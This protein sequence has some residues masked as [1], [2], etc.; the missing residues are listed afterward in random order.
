MSEVTTL[1]PKSSARAGQVR[2]PVTGRMTRLAGIAIVG[3]VVLT[4]CHTDNTPTT[5]GDEVKAAF[6]STCE[7][8]VQV[9][10]GT[11]TS[12]APPAYCVC[13]YGV[14]EQNVP[15]NDDDKKN[16]DNGAKFANYSGKVF[17]DIEK[18]LKDEPE[19]YNDNSVLPQNVRDMVAACPKTSENV[20]TGTTPGSTPGSVPA[21]DQST[22][23][24]PGVGA[25]STL[26][27][28]VASST[29]GST[30]T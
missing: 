19:K 28:T 11:T 14:F 3:L 5:Y 7:G 12:I 20:T 27:T 15:F 25:G 18:D 23:T 30:P 8:N 16:R 6:T 2:V 26:G 10:E 17:V 22:A 9:S 29:P 13:A 1:I 4:G 24:V 21:A